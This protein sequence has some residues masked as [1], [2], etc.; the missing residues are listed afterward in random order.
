MRLRHWHTI[1]RG[2]VDAR[3]SVST[4]THFRWLRHW[5]K[6]RLWLHP[7]N[8]SH[9][10]ITTQLADLLKCHSQR[11]RQPIG[12]FQQRFAWSATSQLACAANEATDDLGTSSDATSPCQ[13]RK[14]R[15]HFLCLL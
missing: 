13:D 1:D 7:A 5:P 6:L 8:E 14:N 9:H 12:H 2:P 10:D 11:T 3:R 4:A 15:K